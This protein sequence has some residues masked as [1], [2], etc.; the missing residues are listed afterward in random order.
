MIQAR[1]TDAE[2]RA[3]K[4]GTAYIGLRLDVGFDSLWTTLVIQERS[5]WWWQPRL[6]ATLDPL[7]WLVLCMETRTLE[8]PEDYA[9]LSEE[10][11]PY[12]IGKYI[13]VTVRTGTYKDKA[14]P[15]VR[16]L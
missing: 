5:R 9:R 7:E 8:T 11:I 16:W 1:I 15:D 13:S 2:V 10:L 14:Y 4:A 12:L 3:S 6:R